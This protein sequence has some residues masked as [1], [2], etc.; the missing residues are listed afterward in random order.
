MHDKS[1]YYIEVYVYH[2]THSAFF[3]SF[4]SSTFS[5]FYS[6]FF[7]DSTYFLSDYRAWASNF[8]YLYYLAAYR[9]MALCTSGWS[10]MLCK[11][12][13]ISVTFLL[14][15][16]YFYPTISLQMSPSFTFG[17]HIMVL[18]LSIGNLKGNCSGKSKSTIRL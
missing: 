6:A 10:S 11:D 12:W 17:C 5:C 3:Y 8:P 7:F 15:C 14:G 18:N 16:H 4:V 13:M 1:L 9:L 2:R